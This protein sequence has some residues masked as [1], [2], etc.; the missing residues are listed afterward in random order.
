M[1]VIDNDGTISIYQGDSGEITVHG[2]NENSSYT[3]YLGIQDENRNTIGEELQVSAVNTDTV[4]FVLSS[5]FTDN[6]V[7]PA[8]KPYKIYYYGI[9]VC[10]DESLTEDTLFIGNG[11]YGDLNRLIVYPRKVK[12]AVNEQV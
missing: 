7:V 2:L 11:M 4:T 5:D 3:A 10:V 8:N 6:L 12:G 1:L 9:K